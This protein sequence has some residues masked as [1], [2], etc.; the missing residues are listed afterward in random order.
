LI[1]ST[2]DDVS[3]DYSPDGKRIAFESR[4][5]GTQEIWSVDADGHDAVQLTNFGGPAVGTPRWSPAGSKVVLNSRKF[6]KADIFVVSANGGTAT[7]LTADGSSNS[8]PA[9]SA[10]GRSIFFGSDRSGQPEIW[11]IPADGGQAIQ[12]TRK[13][14][15][16]VQRAAGDPR[17]YF[18]A[19]GIW[20]MAESGSAEKINDY[21][22]DSYWA[23]WRDG[24][25]VFGNEFT[26]NTFRFR[27]QKWDLLQR[28][29]NPDSP[30][31][32]RRPTMAISPDGRW[33]LLTMTALD[34][35]DL[36]LAEKIQ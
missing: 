4:R 14:A 17:L 27:D 22:W 21:G 35:G 23:P 9:W 30:R 12:V 34:R 19:N 2:R 28:L 36:M 1:A 25:V 8:L 33:V 24:I 13:G 32:P 11:K 20:R 29:P 6:G 31:Y 16:V 18:W 3:P 5:T 7:R 10:D 15:I 26:V